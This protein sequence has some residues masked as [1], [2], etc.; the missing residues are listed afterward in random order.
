MRLL[1]TVAI[2][3]CLPLLLGADISCGPTNTRKNKSILKFTKS[4]S[5]SFDR[6][7]K[8]PAVLNHIGKELSSPFEPF[9][10][11]P[12]RLTEVC[13]D[14]NKVVCE[15]DADPNN[16]RLFESTNGVNGHAWNGSPIDVENRVR[17]VQ[18]RTAAG[19][20]EDHLALVGG[21]S[22]DV[23]AVSVFDIGECSS[24][25]PIKEFAHILT[26]Q[27]R[28]GSEERLGTGDPPGSDDITLWSD[29]TVGLKNG[30]FP[31]EMFFD[32]TIPYFGHF[33]K[34]GEQ[35]DNELV[36]EMVQR[37][38]WRVD[39]D[40]DWNFQRSWLNEDDYF[41]NPTDSRFWEGFSLAVQGLIRFNPV[42]F[43][44]P[45]VLGNC[46]RDRPAVVQMR[47]SFEATDPYYKDWYVEDLGGIGVDVNSES[48]CGPYGNWP[49]SWSTVLAWPARPYCNNHIRGR[50]E[51]WLLSGS[52]VQFGEQPEGV[53][54]DDGR[55]LSVEE[56]LTCTPRGSI[57]PF[58][59]YNGKQLPIRDVVLTPTRAHFVHVTEI[60]IDPT[61]R[62]YAN[63][64]AGA[65]LR[66]LEKA[67]WDEY[68]ELKAQNKCGRDRAI[69]AESVSLRKRGEHL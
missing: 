45:L 9:F 64:I 41:G 55:L 39:G 29:L 23:A 61:G 24:S 35:V 44:L 16:L 60:P 12:D 47:G 53:R 2:L 18:P 20:C 65:V 13:T 34:P 27:L 26:E 6:A 21:Q 38:A 14:E 54:D 3:V 37:T 63:S 67:D 28:K 31:P 52:Y 49:C 22:W 36:A 10:S 42:T 19:I 50:I 15:W 25:I 4:A 48:N 11:T 1:L 8:Q 57:L 58:Q 59:A 17:C 33:A 32:W 69:P 66:E 51:S 62:V 40:M 7:R 68:A 46:E 5:I 56:C 30:D 43:W